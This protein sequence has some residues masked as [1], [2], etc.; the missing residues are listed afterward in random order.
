MPMRTNL[1]LVPFLLAGCGGDVVPSDVVRSD[2]AGVE[3]VT[4]GAN[5]LPLGWNFTEEF[6][7]GGADS[8]AGSFT[9]ASR[10]TVATPTAERIVIFN[11]EQSKIEVYDAQGVLLNSF[12][13]AGSGP[14]EINFA[15][16]LLD[17]GADEVALFD[18][19]KMA[20]VRWTLAG[21]VLPERR[22]APELR[23]IRGDSAW[24]SLQVADSVRSLSGVIF[25]AASDTV[26]LDSLVTP[27]RAM[28]SLSCF[29]AMLPPMF[30]GRVVWDEQ[31]G[32][33]ALTPQ[34]SY[35]VQLYAGAR[36]IR[37]IRR[38]IA[39]V[40]TTPAMARREHPDGWSVSFSNGPDCTL[41]PA[42]VAEKTGMAP[43]L[44]VVADVA[45]GPRNTLWVARHAFPGDTVTTDVFDSAGEYLGSVRDRGVPLGW[46][47]ED[48]VLFAVQDPATGVGVVVVYRIVAS[49]NIN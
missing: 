6:R 41:D 18:Y 49:E 19:G 29:S 9:S 17:V 23:V 26:R 22:I 4:S 48:R 34:S 44:P 10:F 32:V 38:P 12:G 20:M 37:S 47:G 33:V 42:E 30:S 25:A 16:E 45:F 35:V 31:D 40:P 14:G 36:L 3:V 5:D 7:I 13:R 8:G 2:S 39:A 11:R 1:T 43:T 24:G 15:M 27:P 21:E 46:L 28:I